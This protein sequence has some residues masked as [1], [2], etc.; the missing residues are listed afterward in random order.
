MFCA[1]CLYTLCSGLFRIVRNFTSFLLKPKFS[2][3]LPFLQAGPAGSQ[4]GLLACLFVE[5]FQTWQILEQPWR[6]FLE[7][8]AMTL[9]LFSIGLLLPMINNIT[10]IFGFLSGL[11][12]SFA[13][14]PCLTFGTA[15]RYRKGFLAAFSLAAYIGLFTCLVVW[16]YIYPISFHWLQPLTCLPLTRTYCR[17]YNIH[18]NISRVLP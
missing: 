12:L 2:L 4:Y 17:D 11:L 10:H 13:F 15:D 18:H 3:L 7:L 9:L 1:H 5:L 6:A 16:F 8:L 14:L